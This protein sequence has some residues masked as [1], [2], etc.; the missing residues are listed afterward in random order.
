MGTPNIDYEKLAKQKYRTLLKKMFETLS[1]KGMV[2]LIIINDVEALYTN[3]VTIKGAITVFKDLKELGVKFILSFQKICYTIPLL[4]QTPELIKLIDG[5]QI[6]DD[7]MPE[8]ICVKC[9]KEQKIFHLKHK[10]LLAVHPLE[11]YKMRELRAFRNVLIINEWR[12][13]DIKRQSADTQGVVAEYLKRMDQVVL[14]IQKNVQ[15][16]KFIPTEEYYSELKESLEY[17]DRIQSRARML[18]T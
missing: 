10:I 5:I 7:G 2:P 14:Y 13:M 15:D 18:Y 12:Y 11:Y 3:D 4:L 8:E 1:E 16:G 17:L 9:L 6:V